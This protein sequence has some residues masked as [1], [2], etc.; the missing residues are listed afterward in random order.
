MPAKQYSKV[1]E[2]LPD[3]KEIVECLVCLT[4]WEESDQV[5]VTTCFHL[6]H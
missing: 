1:I 5:R 6:F 3:M 2:E 4:P